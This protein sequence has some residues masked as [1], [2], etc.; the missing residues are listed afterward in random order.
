MTII[1]YETANLNK[2]NKPPVFTPEAFQ[3]EILN[4][5]YETVA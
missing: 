4:L 3:V 2:K 5:F 1:K